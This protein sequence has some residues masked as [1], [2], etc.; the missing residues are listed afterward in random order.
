M[1]LGLWVHNM[2]IEA[3]LLV[4]RYYRA[5]LTET[6][7]KSLKKASTYKTQ[8]IINSIHILLDETKCQNIRNQIL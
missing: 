3:H 2:V 1:G 5:G 8:V 6:S 7:G 4:I